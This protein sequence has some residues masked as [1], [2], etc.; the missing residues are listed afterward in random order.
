M[1]SAPTHYFLRVIKL[2][3][4]PMHEELQDEDLMSNCRKKLKFFFTEYKIFSSYLQARCAKPPSGLVS[5]LPIENARAS[6]FGFDLTAA[7][8]KRRSGGE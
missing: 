2:L 1:G 4:G 8:V 5:H 7:K 6:E 3:A